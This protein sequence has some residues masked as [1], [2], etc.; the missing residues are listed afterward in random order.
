MRFVVAVLIAFLIV[1]DLNA[2]VKW[3]SIEPETPH[4]EASQKINLPQLKSVNN[5]FENVKI[6]QHLLD[7]KSVKEEINA[8]SKKNWYI[9]KNIENR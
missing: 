4:K 5:L 8:D 9:I 1:I 6:I 7:K 2:Q 3:I